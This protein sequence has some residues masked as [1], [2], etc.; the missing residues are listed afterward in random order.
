MRLSTYL[1][2]LIG[3]NLIFYLAGYTPIGNQLVDN[4]IASDGSIDILSIT[5]S[6]DNYAEDTLEPTTDEAK[7]S[8]LGILMM[9]IGVSFV[10]LSLVIGF[11]ALY[12]IPMVLLFGVVYLFVFPMSWILDPSMPEALIVIIAFVYNYLTLMAVLTF[13]RGQS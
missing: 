1:A 8:V 12:I 5:A 10:I 13:V 2:L 11:S 3:I 9:G 7:G 4:V 6:G